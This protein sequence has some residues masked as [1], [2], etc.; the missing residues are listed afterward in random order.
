M[1]SNIKLQFDD[2]SLEQEYIQIRNK[3]ITYWS[4]IALLVRSLTILSAAISYFA[5]M[6]Q[7]HYSYWVVR[8][9]IIFFQGLSIFLGHR[10]PKYY[11]NYQAPVYVAL[12]APYLINIKFSG[13]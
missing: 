7:F 5:G 12:W 13:A 4:L 11:F 2:D 8:V 6:R 10:F 1:I 3:D 9:V